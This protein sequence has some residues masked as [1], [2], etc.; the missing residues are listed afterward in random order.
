MINTIVTSGAPRKV[1][2]V[3]SPRALPYAKRCVDSLLRNSCEYL[4]LHLI[5]DSTDDAKRLGEL[6]ANLPLDSRHRCDIFSGT[7]MFDREAAK[8]GGFRNLRALRRGHPC[9]RKITDPLLV[10]QPG[11]ELL[12]LDPDVYFPNR[13]RFEPRPNAGLLLMFQ[14]A[15]CLLPPEIVSRALN[16]GIRL[17]DHVDIGVAHW[18]SDPDLEWIDWLIGTLGG[19]CLPSVMHVE[20]I[21]WA[22]IAMHEGGGYLDPLRWVCWRRTQ[23]TRVEQKLGISGAQILRRERWDDMKCLH[24]GGAS[25]WWLSEC[26][27]ELLRRRRDQVEPSGVI[28]F[29]EFTPKK[30]ARLGRQRTIL[31]TIGYYRLFGSS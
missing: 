4:H 7:E 24:C 13:F 19:S 2:M 28:P 3:L 27:D 15:N 5:T 21:I 11:E 31:H 9:W 16:T 18:R 17:A 14:K 30:F 22:A 26:S 23:V 29:V 8:F 10:S 12:L 1:Y 25:K 6:M 20:A